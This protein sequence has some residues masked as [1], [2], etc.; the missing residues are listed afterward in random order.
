MVWAWVDVVLNEGD[1]STAMRASTPELRLACAQHWV[2]AAQRARVSVVAGWDR[3]DLA[4]AL[5]APDETNPCWPTYAHDRVNSF[6]HFRGINFGAGSRP[7][8]VDLDHERVVLIDLDDNSHGRRTIGGRD[9][10]YRDEGQQIVGWPL[11]AR[12]SRGTWI[13]A[14]YGYDLPVPGWPPALG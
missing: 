7:R 8:P 11:L 12:R 4:R 14:S 5:A 2:L 13:V 3:D 9:L 1:W 10:A 6:S